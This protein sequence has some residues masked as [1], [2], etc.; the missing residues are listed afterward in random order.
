M[1]ARA[2]G[3][4]AERE[5]VLGYLSSGWQ[6]FRPQKTAHYGT[7]DIFNMFDFVAVKNSEVHF[8]QIKKNSTRGF[9]KKLKAWRLAH[10]IKGVK[11]LLW[12]RLDLRKHPEKWKKY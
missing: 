5:A 12:V 11:W 10:P 1:T 4:R 8:V 9:L 7:Q 3:D 2:K 6:V